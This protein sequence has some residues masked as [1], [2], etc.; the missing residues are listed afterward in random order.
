MRRK[1]LVNL[2]GFEHVTFASGGSLPDKR[3]FSVGNYFVISQG[4]IV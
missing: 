2:A 3:K 1:A 4:V